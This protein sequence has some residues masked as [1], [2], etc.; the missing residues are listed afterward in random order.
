MK[1][2]LQVFALAVQ[3]MTRLPMPE[4]PFS[5]ER[6]TEAGKYYPLVGLVVGCIG[7]LVL[8][9]ASLV[10]PVAV[11]VILAVAACLLATGAL[12]EDGLADMADGLGGGA[13][14]ERAMDIMRDSAIGAFG[15]LTLVIVLALK[16]ALLIDLG[17]S[18]AALAMI[19]AHV[20]S[21]YAPVWAIYT[22]TYARSAGAKFTA[23]EMTGRGHVIAL[24]TAASALGLLCLAFGL[25]GLIGGLVAGGLVWVTS[26]LYL[27]KLNGFT[28]DCLG[29]LQQMA[30]LG[31][32]LGVVA[33]L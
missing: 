26:R 23:P 22:Q 29:A 27:R 18:D 32:Y 31:V 6:Q 20:M 7:A 9:S 13:T 17:P 30:E 11:A 15:V 19:A 8:W 14:R 4:V 2:E 21:R 10:L 25:A 16:V 3:F 28:G 33:W 5:A 24:I 1:R 12:H